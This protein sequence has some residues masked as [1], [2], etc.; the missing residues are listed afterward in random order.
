M[1]VLEKL[2]VR[3]EEILA[4]DVIVG[5]DRSG[6][7]ETVV[8]TIPPL[9]SGQ[10]GLKIEH[11]WGSTALYIPRDAWVFIERNAMNDHAPTPATGAYLEP[12]TYDSFPEPV[13]FWIVR[14]DH[15][16]HGPIALNSGHHYREHVKHHAEALAVQHDAEE[17]PEHDC[18]E[19][20]HWP[21]TAVAAARQRR[22]Y[23]AEMA[24]R[25][26]IQADAEN[27][28]DGWRD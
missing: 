28:R 25:A 5:W 21:C 7:R 10:V 2:K 19:G 14:C 23:D 22:A 13:P 27:E 20:T 3:A 17:H 18:A 4:G 24:E 15:P 26:A 1:A 6:K 16:S 9:A 8:S 11:A 12:H